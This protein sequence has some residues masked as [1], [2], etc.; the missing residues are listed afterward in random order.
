MGAES[1]V[2]SRPPAYRA[3]SNWVTTRQEG[4]PNPA[5]RCAEK[6][7]ALGVVVAIQSG[8][9]LPRVCAPWCDPNRNEVPLAALSG[10]SFLKPESKR[11]IWKQFTFNDGKSSPYGFG[12]RISDVRGHKLIGHTGQTAGF[13]AAN[14]RY[15]DDGVTVIVLTNLGELGLG[16][17][18][19][20]RV[21]KFYA[22]GLSLRAMKPD[23]SADAAGELKRAE[24]AIR[25]RLN[26]VISPEVFSPALARSLTTARGQAANKRIATFGPI[27]KIDPVAREVADSATTYRFRAAIGGRL[28][29]W[30]FVFQ[31]DGKVS[32]MTLEE[33]E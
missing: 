9:L 2:I 4:C 25:D 19:A 7:N 17:Q 5:L 33:E 31:S 10:S 30:R 14:F 20:A 28:T 1:F 24:R 27:G 6:I 22:P 8:P 16:G 26:G 15:V 23:A 12:W 13:G 29:L 11:E 21:A 32:E 3:P 18:I